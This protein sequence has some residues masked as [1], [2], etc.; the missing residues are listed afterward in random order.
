MFFFEVPIKPLFRKTAA[1]C[2][3][4]AM[5]ER[6]LKCFR[7]V[8]NCFC[9]YIKEFDPGV[10]FVFLMHPKEAKHQRTGTGRLAQI[11]MTGAEL[12][13]G[14]D[15][16]THTRF[17]QLLKD[18]QYIPVLLYPGENAWTAKSPE[19]KETLGISA[20][21]AAH[22][23][24]PAGV[25]LLVIVVDATWF[26]SRKLIEHN[27]YLLSLPRISF[28]GSYRSIFTIK[29]EPKP[30]YISTIE[31][32]YYLI[33]ELQENGLANPVADPECLMTVFRQMIAFQI[34][35]ENE[36]IEGLRPSTHSYDWKYTKKRVRPVPDFTQSL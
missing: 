19:L 10:K 3:S 4:G 12:L 14:L 15:F 30:E 32:C 5:S 35:A 34:K 22:G 27:T 23:A 1:L 9:K 36:R 29:R 16:S 31:S 8:E 7:P 2:Y 25:T 18:P 33:K 26:C 20:D 24:V 13:V 11:S 28:Y 21:T 6:C 17:Q